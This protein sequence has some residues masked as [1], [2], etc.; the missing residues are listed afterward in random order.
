MLKIV[1]HKAWAITI[2]TIKSVGPMI[3]RVKSVGSRGSGCPQCH[4][5]GSGCPQCHGT[6]CRLCRCAT[7]ALN[8][9]Q[10]AS[11]SSVSHRAAMSCRRSV[12]PHPVSTVPLICL[13]SASSVSHLARATEKHAWTQPKSHRAAG[14]GRLQCHRDCT[15]WCVAS[16][17]LLG[18][19]PGRPDSSPVSHLAAESSSPQC[20]GAWCR[21][22]G[23]TAS[24]P[25]PAHCVEVSQ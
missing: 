23:C 6:W 21:L 1:K 13:Q 11:S 3:C 2:L 7:V 16:N 4:A 8:R 20:H 10:Q 9:W 24:D 14:S 19:S 25:L 22:C 17:P 12:S 15:C 5:A 18:Q